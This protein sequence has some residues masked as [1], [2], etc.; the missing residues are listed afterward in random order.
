M[1]RDIKRI[2]MDFNTY[3]TLFSP[4][5]EFDNRRDAAQQEWDRH[6]EK[7]ESII[8]WLRLH[9]AY[10]GRNPY[11]FIQDWKVKQPRQQTL[12]YA[13]YYAHFGTTEE[14]GGWIRR[15]L[16]DKQTTIFIKQ[17]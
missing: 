7:H 10:K 16:P 6:P 1:G 2:I 13:D 4:D 8:C 11:F 9:G 14:Q 3:W 17:C 12:S 5:A 15:F